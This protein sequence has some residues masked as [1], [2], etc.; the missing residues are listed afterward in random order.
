MDRIRIFLY[1]IKNLLSH[2]PVIWNSPTHDYY[3]IM[4][5]TIFKLK[6]LLELKEKLVDQL[7]DL[8]DY[9]DVDIPKIKTAIALFERAY[10]D[11]YFDQISEI[12]KLEYGEDVLK[13]DFVRVEDEN[14]NSKYFTLR[15]AYDSWENAKEVGERYRYLVNK[16]NRKQEKVE[17]LCWQYFAYY[18]KNW[19]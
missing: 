9:H 10:N 8:D 17:K 5:M 6:K 13:I 15:N 3:S 4:D 2:V 1:K 16:Y 12:M 11:Y 19:W 7:K 18:G 14:N